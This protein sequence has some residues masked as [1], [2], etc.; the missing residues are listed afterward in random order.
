M[1]VWRVSPPGGGL[2]PKGAPLGPLKGPFGAQRPFGP[3]GGMPSGMPVR[4]AYVR[5]ACPLSV[6]ERQSKANIM[7]YISRLLF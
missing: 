6:P 5:R 1:A 2:R 4:H 3:L 7:L